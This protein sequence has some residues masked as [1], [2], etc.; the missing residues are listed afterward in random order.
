MAQRRDGHRTLLALLD[1]PGRAPMRQEAAYLD[2]WLQL[3]FQDEVIRQVG[4]TFE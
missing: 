4:I 3:G 1:R 2:T